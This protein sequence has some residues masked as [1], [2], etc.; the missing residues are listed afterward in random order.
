VRCWHT[1]CDLPH[2]W[3]RCTSSVRLR[4]THPGC[5]QKGLHGWPPFLLPPAASSSAPASSGTRSPTTWP[6]SAGPTSSSS[7]RARCPTPAAP[8]ATRATSSSRSTTPASSPTSR[9]T[10]CASTRSWASSPSPAAIEVARTEERMEEL[11]RRMSSAKAWGI[12]AELVTPEQVVE[13]VPFLDPSVIIGAAWFPTVGVVDSLRAGTIMRE[14]RVEKGAL[15]SSPTS[16]SRASRSSTAHPRR[17]DHQGRIEAE[18]VVIACGVWSPKIARMAGAQHPA[19]PRRAPDDLGRPRARCSPSVPVRSASR[20]CATWTP[21]ATSA[22]T[23]RTWR[24]APTPTAPSSGPRGHPLHRAEQAL[25]HRAAVHRGR[26]RPAARAGARAH[27]R[28]ARRRA[29]RDPLRHQRPALADPRR[30][31][32]P[33]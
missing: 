10:P 18:T 24:S 6:S 16:R 14:K 19:H 21:S 25:P 28:A 20:S 7:T 13:K 1:P 3:P 27:A 5:R 23:A 9:W 8:R 22:S 26:L 31:P 32:D 12:P 33:R 15:T 17:R 30:L 11:R 4:H 29:R 2:W